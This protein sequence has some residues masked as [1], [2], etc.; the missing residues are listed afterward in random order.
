[1]YRVQRLFGTPAYVRKP[2]TTT[3][4]VT[5]GRTNYTYDTYFVRRLAIV[6][7]DKQ[8]HFIYDLTY[9]AANKN[10]AYGGFFTTAQMI[11]ILN[12]DDIPRNVVIDETWDIIINS[13]KHQI[14]KVAMI[15]EARIAVLALKLLEN[16]PPI[17]VL[18]QLP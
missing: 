11:G 14:E 2:N 6:P 16:T 5:T 15:E 7:G 3:E 8:Q 18:A 12:T 1:M 13:R 9:L 17:D 10:F 4:D